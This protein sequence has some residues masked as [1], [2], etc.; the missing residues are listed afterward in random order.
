MEERRKGVRV[1]GEAV[2]S[3]DHVDNRTGG[4]AMSTPAVVTTA[5]DIERLTAPLVL[6]FAAD[7]M[8]R[9]LLPDPQQFLLY[10]PQIV[11]VHAR[12]VVAHGGAFHTADFR[13]AALW[14]PPGSQV[15]G[16]ALGQ[17]LARAVAPQRL[18]TALTLFARMGEY[19]PAGSH[20]YLRQIGVDPALQ[21][22]GYGSLLLRQ[23]LETCDRA[24]LPAYLEATSSA[25]R[26]LYEAFGFVAAAELQIADS[27]PLWPMTRGG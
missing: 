25:N 7:A 16:E 27:P 6:A 3:A 15:D 11:Q 26:R 9:W 21:G 8:V 12:R 1:W 19:K 5:I 20:W 4:A 22:R 23:G 17:V 10:F 18:Q 13:G 14:Y 24:G 2:A